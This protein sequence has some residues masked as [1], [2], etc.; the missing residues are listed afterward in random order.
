MPRSWSDADLDDLIEEILVDTYGD[1]NRLS[2][3]ECAFDEAGPPVA[4]E[5]LGMACWLV[6]VRFDGGQR[7]GLEGEIDSH[8]V[9][10]PD[11]HDA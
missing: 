2:S 9:P 1:S 7:R 3:F 4:A 11:E 10:A 5:A 8:I 6:A